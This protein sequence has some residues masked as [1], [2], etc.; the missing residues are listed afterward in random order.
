MGGGP[1]GNSWRQNMIKQLDKEQA[2]RIEQRRARQ[3]AY[4]RANRERLLAKQAVYGAAHRD[5][6]RAYEKAYRAKN[7]EKLRAYNT[8]YMAAYRA[9]RRAEQQPLPKAAGNRAR[10]KTPDSG[11]RRA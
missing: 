11:R 7:R 1:V 10:G 4:Y 5:E 9:K 2:T 6:R 3:A 8:A